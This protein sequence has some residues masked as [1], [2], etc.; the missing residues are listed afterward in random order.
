L[1]EKTCAVPLLERKRRLLAIMPK[2]QNRLLFLDN[3][4]ERW[5]R[6]VSCGVR[7]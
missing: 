7:A 1:T 5:L 6:L 4:A 2:V 3:I